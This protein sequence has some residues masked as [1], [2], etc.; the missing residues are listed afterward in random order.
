MRYALVMVCVIEP[1]AAS[2]TERVWQSV[3]A[4]VAAAAHA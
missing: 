2:G 1:P 3:V 4:V